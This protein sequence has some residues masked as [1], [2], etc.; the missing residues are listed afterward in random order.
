M[1]GL[2]AVAGSIPVPT[3]RTAEKRPQPPLGIASYSLRK[4]STA[5]AIAMCKRLEVSA[6]CFKDMHL[7]FTASP[8]EIKETVAKVQSAGLELT[9]LGVIYM[10]DE[11]T[12]NMA[13]AYA[14]AAAVKMIVGAPNVELLQ[15]CEKKVKE[16]GIILAIHNHGPDNTLYPGPGDAYRLIRNL[17]PRIGL[18]MDVGHTVRNGEDAIAAVKKYINRLYD[19]HIKDVTAASKMGETVE[20]G[21]GIIDIP[22]LIDTLLKVKYKGALSLEFEK[23]AED[24]LPGMA[25][26]IGYVKGVLASL[27]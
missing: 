17:D 6:V 16:T 23:D 19:V 3:A 25:E 7:P 18:C 1:T 9:G 4:F 21:R 13:F 11:K 14:Q 24:P 20:I 15:L 12:V 26:S 2:A 10:K 8:Q 22:K 5:E 27:S